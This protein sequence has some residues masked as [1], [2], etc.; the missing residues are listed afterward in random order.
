MKGYDK[1]AI[2]TARWS[3]EDLIAEAEVP[4]LTNQ[5]L[6]D[7]NVGAKWF[8]E[9]AGDLGIN[10]FTIQ[11]NLKALSCCKMKIY[12]AYIKRTGTIIWN[13][14]HKHFLV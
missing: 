7:Y 5:H 4:R 1:D 12:K 11:E 9:L 2:I 3:V 8:Y 10:T 6:N 14:N 13:G